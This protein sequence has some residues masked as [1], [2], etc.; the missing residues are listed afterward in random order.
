MMT[1]DFDHQV[2]HNDSEDLTF[3]AFSGIN[4]KNGHLEMDSLK[5]LGAGVDGTTGHFA[6]LWAAWHSVCARAGCL[7]P[8]GTKIPYTEKWQEEDFL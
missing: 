1:D 3:K 6:W 8:V 2:V 4:W 7:E 5:P